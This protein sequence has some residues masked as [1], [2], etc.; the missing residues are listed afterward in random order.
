LHEIPNRCGVAGIEAA[1]GNLPDV[2]ASP[3]MLNFSRYEKTQS[4]QPKFTAEAAQANMG[5][6][7][8]R[9]GLARAAV[10]NFFLINQESRHFPRD[11]VVRG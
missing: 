11:Q 9:C 5:N 6:C 7:L 10:L 8:C 1:S 4:F 3:N 2:A